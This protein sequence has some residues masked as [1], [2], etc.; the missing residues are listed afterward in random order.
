ML[1][2]Q[3]YTFRKTPDLTIWLAF[4]MSWDKIP[5]GTEACSSSFLEFW[6]P[7]YLNCFYCLHHLTPPWQLKAVLVAW[8]E[9][10]FNSSFGKTSDTVSWRV[11]SAVPQ[12]VPCSPIFL[13]GTGWCLETQTTA[14]L[15][16]VSVGFAV[17]CFLR[18]FHY[19][20]I[21]NPSTMTI[22]IEEIWN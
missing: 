9:Y 22:A 2:I 11:S 14:M 18:M 3:L 4:F 8:V 17:F 6:S 20:L 1:L 21:V 10:C 7:V 12:N 5:V 19:L 16:A 13:F 15:S